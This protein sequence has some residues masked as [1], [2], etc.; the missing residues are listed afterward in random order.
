MNNIPRKQTKFKNV[1]VHYK[2][3]VLY[4]FNFCKF[5]FTKN[6]RWRNEQSETIRIPH[7]RCRAQTNLNSFIP[8]D[9][10]SRV[11]CPLQ[12]D[13]VAQPFQTSLLKA[14]QFHQ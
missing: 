7:A 2:I 11:S 12:G 4:Y 10:Q 13:K 1:S 3:S 8:E 9:H 14:C 5:V 6:C